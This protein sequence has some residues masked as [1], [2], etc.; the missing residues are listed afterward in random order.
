VTAAE[1]ALCQAADRYRSS[2]TNPAEVALLDAGQE[3]ARERGQA[4]LVADMH[5]ARSKGLHAGTDPRSTRFRTRACRLLCK[6]ADA[7]REV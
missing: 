3:L 6:V 4:E 5:K 7:L 2:R 1:T